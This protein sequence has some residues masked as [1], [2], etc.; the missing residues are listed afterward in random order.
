MQNIHS[1]V[2]DNK[3]HNI[4]ILLLLFLIS[5]IIPIIINAGSVRLSIYCI[6]L[7][8]GFAPVIIIFMKTTKFKINRTDIYIFLFCLWSSIALIVNHGIEFSFEPIGILFL[9]TMGAYLFGRCFVTN[10]V[11]LF[12][13][14]RIFFVIT[15]IFTPLAIFEA[16]TGVN[17]ALQAFGAI[18]PVFENVPKDP[19]W[20]LDRVQGPFEHPILF[21]VYFGCFISM[22]FYIVCYK[23]SYLSKTLCALLVVFISA[24]CLSSGPLTAFVAQIALISWDLIFSRVKKKWTILSI[25][26]VLMWITVDII[27]NRSP[28]EVFISY[29]AFSEATAYN[30]ILIWDFGIIS[31]KEFPVFGIGFHEWKRAWFMSTSFDMFWLL[32]AV[33]F[34]LLGGVF[35]MMAFFSTTIALIRAKISDKKVS[36]YRKA[37][38]FTLI[39]FFLVGWTVHFWNATYVLLVFLFGCCQWLR[40]YA[41]EDTAVPSDI[42]AAQP[43]RI[44]AILGQAED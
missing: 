15:L 30:R 19:R 10:S 35:M 43:P 22:T 37:L 34:G 23:Y 18:G 27:S 6:I 28:P 7:I 9:E 13:T 17:I 12:K 8:I 39:G 14:A 24:L 26:V 25:L 20:G 33:T 41:D 36:A 1:R 11:L 42:D 5:V 44:R 4:H 40:D 2:S 31:V 21:G 16:V 3:N 38:V 32:N 29:F